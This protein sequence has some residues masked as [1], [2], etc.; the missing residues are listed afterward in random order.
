MISTEKYI[1]QQQLLIKL[2]QYIEYICTMLLIPQTI[3]SVY[4]AMTTDKASVRHTHTHMGTEPPRLKHT[5]QTDA[6]KLQRQ[7]FTTEVMME[8][9]QCPLQTSG[10]MVYTMKG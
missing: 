3:S 1:I 6:V 9:L 2:A 10:K 5:V 7:R 8:S 4:C